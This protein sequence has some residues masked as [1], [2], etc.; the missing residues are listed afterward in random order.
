MAHAF[1]T[2]GHGRRPIGE[3]VDLLREVEVTLLADVR[4]MPRS[5]ANPQFNEDALPQALQPFGI[6][7]AH[8]TDLGGLRGRQKSVAPEINGFWENDSFHNY[9][10]YALSDEFRHGLVQGRQMQRIKRRIDDKDGDQQNQWQRH[11]E[12]GGGFSP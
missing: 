12:G 10:D 9:A 8:M 11:Q 1:Y 5:R 4:T 2:I 7:Y 3:F 6:A